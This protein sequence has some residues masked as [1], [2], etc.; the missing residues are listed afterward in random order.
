MFATS[1]ILYALDREDPTVEIRAIRQIQA[2]LIH[3]IRTTHTT[4]TTHTINKTINICLIASAGDTICSILSSGINDPLY[5]F[6]LVDINY[7]QMKLTL[8]K[9]GL[10]ATFDGETNLKH[11]SDRL[12]KN[13]AL[14]MLDRLYIDE[15]KI[16]QDTYIYWIDNIGLLTYGIGRS[17]RFELLLEKKRSA[18]LE[19]DRVF[20]RETMINNFGPSSVRFNPVPHGDYLELVSKVYKYTYKTPA[21][22]YFY[23]QFVNNIP[24]SLRAQKKNKLPIYLQNKKPIDLNSSI[25]YYVRDIYLHFVQTESSFYDLIHLS[26]IIDRV[27]PA[28]FKILMDEVTRLLRPNGKVIFRRTNSSTTLKSLINKYCRNLCLN[29][30]SPYNYFVEF[31][32]VDKSCFFSEVIIMTKIMSSI[33]TK[34]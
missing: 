15:K 18:K 13:Y 3:S 22:N 25:Y 20:N 29:L 16:D 28:N 33:S 34:E 32:V 14:E 2:N 11:I 21:D 5:R 31:D 8:L 12:D 30:L 24:Y 17:G 1:P 7:D 9:I 6:D 23:Y 27:N 10:I 26:S 4:H 19:F